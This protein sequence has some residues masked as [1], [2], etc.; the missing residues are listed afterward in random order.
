MKK[1]QVKG[2]KIYVPEIINGLTSEISKIRKVYNKIKPDIVGI[3]ASEEELNGLRKVVEGE[4]LEYFLS[5][6]EEIYARKLAT[7]GEVKIPPPCYEEAMKLCLENDT[8]IAALDM[9]D[10][11]FA[12]VF[13][14]NIS[15]WQLYR[16]SLR[17]R[18][19]RRKRFKAKTA[20]EFVFEWDKEINKLKGFRNLETKREE[21]MAKELGRLAEEHDR[22]LCIVEM[23]RAEGICKRVIEEEKISEEDE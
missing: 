16:H 22:I 3:Q 8:P 17:V 10:M 6:Y 18:R 7:F 15:G 13:C 20:E 5:N 2:S 9:D 19:L 11:L 4:K 21:H 14:E 1:I 23:Q 12:D